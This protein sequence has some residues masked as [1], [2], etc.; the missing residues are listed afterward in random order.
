M[1]VIFGFILLGIFAIFFFYLS[2]E[3]T[4]AQAEKYK[5]KRLQERR[6][7]ILGQ[8]QQ[9]RDDAD[10]GSIYVEEPNRDWI[11]N[12]PLGQEYLA[13]YDEAL[14]RKYEEKR[15][16]ELAEEKATVIKEIEN[17]LAE[18]KRALS[19]EPPDQSYNYK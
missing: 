4:P 10:F 15:K 9:A 16:K 14:T 2:T 5:E 1:E 18:I 17:I 6:L 3:A 13:R 12:Q 11:A 7:Q 8:L 19:G